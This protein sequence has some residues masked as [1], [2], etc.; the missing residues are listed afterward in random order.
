MYNLSPAT[1]QACLRGSL[2][3]GFILDE[4]ELGRFRV[5]HCQTNEANDFLVGKSASGIWAIRGGEELRDVIV[6]V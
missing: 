1:L 5:C 3:G 2:F 6:L 4:L